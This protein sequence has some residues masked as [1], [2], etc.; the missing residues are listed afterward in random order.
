MSDL[1][2]IHDP[3]LSSL[4][5]EGMFTFFCVVLRP[6]AGHGLLILEVSRSHTTTHHIRQDSSGRVISSSQRPLPDR[7]QHSQ[8]T[9]MLPLEFEPTISAGQRPQTYALDRAAGHWDRLYSFIP[10]YEYMFHL[11]HKNC[12]RS[13]SLSARI[14]SVPS[15]SPTWPQK[16]VN[17]CRA[18]YCSG[19]Y[20]AKTCI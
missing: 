3:V 13:R 2:H 14:F 11:S 12:L 5:M 8:Q 7:T 16:K 18:G 6:N 10:I 19:T 20:H 4:K 17:L 1:R 15:N 9:S